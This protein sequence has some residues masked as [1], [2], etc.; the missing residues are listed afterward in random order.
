L[1]RA[2]SGRATAAVAHD[3]ENEPAVLWSE[4]DERGWESRKVD[5][6]RDG[7]LDDAD[8]SHST[9]TTQ[10]S[11]QAMPTLA[12]I[13]ARDGFDAA[14]TSPDGFENVWRLATAR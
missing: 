7:R 11:D 2:R 5:E 12:E 3:D 6:Y 13:N 10:L 4:I 14:P 9:G 8:K 1:R